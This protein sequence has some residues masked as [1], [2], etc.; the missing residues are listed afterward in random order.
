MKYTFPPLWPIQL[1]IQ[2][3]DRYAGICSRANILV[4]VLVPKARVGCKLIYMAKYLKLDT[5]AGLAR[6]VGDQFAF[7]GR[8]I[9]STTITTYNV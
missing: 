3:S 8:G 1:E 2:L 7:F 5:L 6:Q 9:H 4:K